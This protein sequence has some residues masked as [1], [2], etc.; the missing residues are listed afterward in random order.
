MDSFDLL[1]GSDE[2][3]DV[4]HCC[5]VGKV[6]APKLLNRPAVSN[7]LRG[8]WKTRRGVSITS[9]NDNIFLFQFEDVE[10]RQRI[11]DESPWSVMGSLLVLRPLQI[12]LATTELEFRWSPFWVQ[13]HGLPIDKMT[14]AHGEV[15][16]N[17][18]GRLVEVEAPTTG[19]LL[20]R[21]F[22]RL[23]V[24]VDVFKP[25]LQGFILYRKDN[26][27]PVGGQIEFGIWTRAKNWSCE[28]FGLSF[29][30]TAAVYAGKTTGAGNKTLH[31]STLSGR[32]ATESSPPYDGLPRTP[33]VIPESSPVVN[34]PPHGIEEEHGPSGRITTVPQIASNLGLEDISEVPCAGQ[35]EAGPKSSY[36]VTEPTEESPT[37]LQP[38]VTTH[39]SVIR[40]EELSRSPSPEQYQP[41]HLLMDISMSQVFKSLSLK[42]PISE[43][44]CSG[45]LNPKRC[46]WESSTGLPQ[47]RPERSKGFT[48]YGS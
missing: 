9:W 44:D 30:S 15:I 14:R 5:L 25:L 46:K 4:S 2:C 19:L 37:V 10:D 47:Q 40:V 21:N 41:N 43:D 6:L 7:I 13:V 39:Q 26:I 32:G 16:G 8:A 1:E 35:L 24:E 36:F 17:R 29:G 12:G 38:I 34:L 11:L 3:E 27:G 48:H 42:R 33:L 45:Q 20:H 18:I 23:R 22:L 31:F 28:K